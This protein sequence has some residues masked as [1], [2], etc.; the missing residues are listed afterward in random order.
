MIPIASGII[1]RAD[2]VIGDCLRR[3]DARP[4]P[5]QESETEVNVLIVGAERLVQPARVFQGQ[6]VIDGRAS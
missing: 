6:A 4:P 2:P 5:K 1:G 3:G